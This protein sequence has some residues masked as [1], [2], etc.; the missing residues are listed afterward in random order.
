MEKMHLAGIM[1]VL[2]KGYECEDVKLELSAGNAQ[3]GI[4]YQVFFTYQNQKYLV[5]GSRL[6]IV[7]KRLIDLLRRLDI[8]GF[9][10]R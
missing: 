9:L 5:D 4:W 10:K 1:T 7:K 3:T 8:D 6:D 2:F